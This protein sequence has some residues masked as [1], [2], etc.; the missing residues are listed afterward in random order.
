MAQWPENPLDWVIEEIKQRDEGL[1]MNIADLGCGEGRLAIELKDRPNL[2]VKSYDLCATAEH[3]TVAD[4]AH[5]PLKDCYLDVAVFCLSLMGSNHIEFLRE[6][7]R[8]LKKR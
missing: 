3:V 8:C 6:A 4:I 5:L 1:R 7:R 2:K